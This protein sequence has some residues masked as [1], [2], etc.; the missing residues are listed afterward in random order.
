MLTGL[1]AP[2]AAGALLS[3]FALVSVACASMELLAAAADGA[4]ALVF[5][6]ACVVI[7]PV[8]FLV[9]Y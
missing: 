8:L 2:G 6:A 9:R 3:S 4:P 7:E 5:V 1:E